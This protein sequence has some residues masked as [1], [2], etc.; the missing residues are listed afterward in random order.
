MG[1][2]YSRLSQ[3]ALT[4]LIN[5]SST[6][7]IP[8][9]VIPKQVPGLPHAMLPGLNT[10]LDGSPNSLITGNTASLPYSLGA[11]TSCPTDGTDACIQLRLDA[12]GYAVNQLFQ[13]A[14]A[15]GKIT[16]QFRIGLDPFIQ[17][18]YST[19]FPLTTSINGDPSNSSTINYAAANLAQLLGTN[20][21]SNLGSGGT[22]IGTALTSINT[23][24]TSVGDGSAFNKTVPYAS[25]SPTAHRIRKS[26]AFPTATGPAATTPLRLINR[27]QSPLSPPVRPSKPRHHRFRAL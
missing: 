9:Q 22:H 17:S 5:S 24:I 26:K 18:L 12:V 11:A 16:G 14:N 20:M 13:T 23:R 10:A 6:Q 8:N 27:A 3:S 7:V 19:Y 21:N 1:Y 25:S 15:D 4:K 2:V